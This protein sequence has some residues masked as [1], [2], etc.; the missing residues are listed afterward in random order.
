MM[1]TGGRELTA[2]ETHASHRRRARGNHLRSD[3]LRRRQAVPDARN[4]RGVRLDPLRRRFLCVQQD[5]R[6]VRRL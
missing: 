4:R 1:V 5:L 2:A 6:A 3:D